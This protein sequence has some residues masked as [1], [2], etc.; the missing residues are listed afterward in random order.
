MF[1]DRKLETLASEVAS[2]GV[3]LN[4][5]SSNEHAPKIERRNRV[6]KERIY[7]PPAVE[8][9]SINDKIDDNVNEAEMEP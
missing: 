5:V 2:L 4:I 9:D 8:Q 6:I 1:M 7:Y 3:T